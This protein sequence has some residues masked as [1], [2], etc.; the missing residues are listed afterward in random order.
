MRIAVSSSPFRRP[1]GA[2]ELTQLEW[3]ERCASVLGVDGVLPD[4]V[5]FP[6]TDGEYIAQLRKVAVDLAIVPLG[7][8]AQGLFDPQLDQAERERPLAVVA[9]LGGMI[10]RA[11]L[12]PPG[13]VPPAA[14]VAAVALAKTASR[15]A[16]GINVTL[17]VP[18]RPGTLA[19]DTDGIKH[20]LK[21]VDSAWLRACPRALAGTDG[22]GAKERFP[23]FEASVEDDPAQ[24]A[25]RV[26]NGWVI[27]DA[28]PGE[29][30]WERL[31]EAIHALRAAEADL[32]HLARS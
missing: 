30:P 22:W 13:E 9:M 2:G 5:D 8:H 7:L 1:L 12:P 6:R 21:D 10:L 24:V 31:G 27:V 20:L 19:P 26:G 4:L 25:A 17:V 23:T 3:L 11:P 29:Q 18:A 16:K 14:F 28:A 32:R 15:A